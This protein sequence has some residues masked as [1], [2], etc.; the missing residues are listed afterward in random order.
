MSV[1]HAS[2]VNEYTA[3]VVEIRNALENLL[4]WVNSLPAPDDNNEL[5][6][7]HYG[8]MGTIG[9]IHDLLGQVSQAAD[10]FHE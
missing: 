3:N 9:H 5:H 2:A 1:K 8:H 4:E 10:G 7:L 6:S